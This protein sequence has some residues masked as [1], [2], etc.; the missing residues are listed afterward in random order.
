MSYKLFGAVVALNLL[1]ERCQD[2]FLATEKADEKL[3][4]R[5][6]LDQSTGLRTFTL[7]C[8][9][10]TGSSETAFLRQKKADG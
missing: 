10:V 4:Y 6:Y 7:A 2:R 9:E 5:V 8:G 1:D 3:T